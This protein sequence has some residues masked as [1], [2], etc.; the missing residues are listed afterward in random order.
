V[1]L[2]GAQ[3]SAGWRQLQRH[4]VGGPVGLVP[5]DAIQEFSHLPTNFLPSMTSSGPFINVVTSRGRHRTWERIPTVPTEEPASEPNCFDK[6]TGRLSKNRGACSSSVGTVG[7]RS[8]V[9]CSSRIRHHIYEGTDDVLLG[10]NWLVND[11]IPDCIFG[12]EAGLAA[13]KL[14]LKLPPS[15]LMPELRC[16]STARHHAAVKPF[17][18]VHRGRRAAPE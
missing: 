7:I 8:H 12:Y 1:L 16:C 6:T 5:E 3:V 15:T 13:H 2:H 18:W 10:K 17:G 11:W 4:I 14:S 9:R